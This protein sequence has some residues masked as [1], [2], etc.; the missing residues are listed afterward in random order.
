MERVRTALRTMRVGFK[1]I[2]TTTDESALDWDYAAEVYNFRTE[3]GTLTGRLGVGE[4][5]GFLRNVEGARFTYPAL[6]AGAVVT[7]LFHYRRNEAGQADDRLVVQTSTGKLYYTTVFANGSWQE[8]AGDFTLAGE[9]SAVNYNYSDRDVLLLTSAQSGLAV[10]D[11]DEVKQVGAAPHF[12]SV[13][14][15][16]ERVYGTLA[17]NNKQL[18]FSD[19]FDPENWNV[20]SEEAGYISFADECGDAL[21]AVSFAGYLYIFREHGIYRLT[22]YGDQSDFVLKKVFTSVGRIYKDTIALCGDRIMFLT[23]DGV[24]TFDGYGV[25]ESVKEL[26]ELVFPAQ[27]RAAYHDGAYWLACT[28]DLG[29]LSPGIATNNTLVRYDIEGGGT[30]FLA[31][32]DF[33]GVTSLRSHN[34]ADLVLN[35]WVDEASAIASLT[36]DGKAFGTATKKIYRSPYGDL[37]SP[38]V[39]T[40]RDVTLSTRYD[41]EL[42][43][44][45]DGLTHRFPLAGS[46]QPQRVFVGKSGR[47]LGIELRSATGECHITQPVVRIDFME[48]RW[49]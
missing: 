39:K 2:V 14:V 41:A 37:F 24:R 1:G 40:V 9:A 3:K 30:D 18:W 35:M 42:R 26:P 45:T 12:S 13:T 10:L 8:V 11:D 27:C 19:D 25:K 28:L 32:Y 20:S 43:V 36:E 33:K 46:E 4:G 5:K 6:P 22:A 21:A 44:V 7:G 47:E 23:D 49:V 16:N 48:E 29:E 31:G 15:H 34:A 38:A 17:G